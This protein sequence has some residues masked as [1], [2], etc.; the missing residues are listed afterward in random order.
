MCIR[1]STIT[2]D[3]IDAAMAIFGKDVAGLKGKTTRTKPKHVVGYRL[4]ITKEILDKH[5]DVYLTA[6]IFFVNQV[7]FFLS[8]SR[9]INYTGVENLTDRKTQTIFQA[10]VAIYKVYRRRNFIIT[11]I[12]V[13][14][15]FAALK[16]RIEAMPGGPRV[17]LATAKEHVP[18]IE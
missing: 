11:T 12:S 13:D 16:E 17:N 4:K 2:V 5:R 18:E 6:D 15:E 7:I 14:G 3:D 10:F 9:K 8:Y 1:D